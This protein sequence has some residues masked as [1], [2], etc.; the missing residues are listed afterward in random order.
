MSNA[1]VLSLLAIAS[2]KRIREISDRT[3]WKITMQEEGRGRKGDG[4]H[5]QFFV[6]LCFVFN[7]CRDIALNLN[8]S[9]WHC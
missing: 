6:L 4:L 3:N 7:F 8:G 5:E 9:C 2:P 1:I